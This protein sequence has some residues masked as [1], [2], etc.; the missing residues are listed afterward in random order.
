MFGEQGLKSTTLF[1]Q[2]SSSGT[3]N[4][5]DSVAFEDVAVRFSLEEWALLQPSQKQ[6]Y[7]DVMGETFR[8]LA[9]VGK[10]WEGHDI[11]D[12]YTHQGRKCR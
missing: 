3:R 4:K 12:Q 7:R 9:S 5:S 8:N 2:P 1:L 11:E 6:L 10:K